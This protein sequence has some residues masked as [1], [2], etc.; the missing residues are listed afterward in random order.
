[1]KLF[2]CI[3]LLTLVLAFVS[4]DERKLAT[5]AC[6]SL[7][8]SESVS[9]T[10]NI[11]DRI[12]PLEIVAL[13]TTEESLLGSV[14]KLLEVNDKYYVLDYVNKC[15]LVFDETGK[16]SH[17]VG[18]VGQGPGEYSALSDFIVDTKNGY[19]Y[20]LTNSS[21]IYAYDNG[22]DFLWKRKISNSQLWYIG[23][24]VNWLL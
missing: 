9:D 19:I 12:C 18:R 4:C 7:D 14:G 23:S 16:F 3:N 15:V 17:R 8:L 13:E 2:G 1:M 21:T 5:N 11:L 22:G 10:L 20:L 6:I 24:S